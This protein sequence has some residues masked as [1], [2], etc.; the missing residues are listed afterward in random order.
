MPHDPLAES[1]RL[2]QGNGGEDAHTAPSCPL[3][4]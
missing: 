2:V 4:V 3:K 1:F